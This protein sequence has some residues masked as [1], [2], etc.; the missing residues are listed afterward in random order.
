MKLIPSLRVRV[1]L[2]GLAVSLLICIV[3]AQTLFSQ[4]LSLVPGVVKEI[5]RGKGRLT[6]LGLVRNE[7]VEE[8]TVRVHP[9]VRKGRTWKRLSVGEGVDL[10]LET[11]ENQRF[12]RAIL[13]RNKRALPFILRERAQKEGILLSD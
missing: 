12:A 1:L 7:R 8:M 4:E 13:P 10:H 5:D 2:A 6:I 9:D 11:V 3:G